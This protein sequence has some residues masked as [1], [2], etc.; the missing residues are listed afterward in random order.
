M[1]GICGIFQLDGTP[2]E[3]SPLAEMNATLAHRGPDDDGFYVASAIGLG[4]RRLSIID[5]G[6]GH[7]PLSNEDQSIWVVFNGEIYNFLDL[8]NELLSQ[9]HSFRT[10]SDT[11]VIAHLY[12]AYGADLLPKLRGMFAFAVW[13]SR[14]RSLLLARDRVGKKPLYYTR[15]GQCLIFASEIKAI[16]KHPAVYA[17]VN[18][19]AIYN[20]LNYQ[21]VP[22]PQTA[23]AGIYKLPPASYLQ[24]DRNSQ[25]IERYWQLNFAPKLNLSE[26]DCCTR[27]RELLEEAV[28]IR[29]MSEVPLGAFLSGGIDSSVIVGLMSKLNSQP[30][31][32]FSIG[33]LEQE[34]NETGYAQ[35]VAKHFHTDHQE[36]TVKPQAL[37]ILPKLIWHYNEPFAD[38][39]ALPTFYVCQMSRRYV[40]VALC[41]DGGDEGFAGYE[42]YLM[43]KWAAI[44][45]KLPD[46]L[47]RSVFAALSRKLAHTFPAQAFFGRLHNFFQR[48]SL[49]AAEL[50]NQ[51]MSVFTP[52]SRQDLYTQDLLAAGCGD[53]LPDLFAQ[54]GDWDNLDRVLWVD[55]HSYLPD[56]L[57]VKAD[58]A[59]MANSL[60]VRSPFLDHKVLEF[61]AGLPSHYK[62]KGLT[63]LKYILRRAFADFL[64]PPILG[65]KKMGFSVPLASWF[66]GELKG[67]VYEVLFSAQSRCRGYFQPHALEKLLVE[68]TSGKFDHSFKLWNLLMLELW[69]RTFIDR[70]G[71]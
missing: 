7:Q 27:L 32:T 33:F 54:T 56:D 10:H 51:L 41:G 15:Q 30:V 28:K 17:H 11:E 43:H 57:L 70:R 71:G 22:S 58:V 21:Y 14:R 62:I 64:P 68:H 67:Y 2:V 12:E 25:R 5:L 60:E 35:I 18:L 13:D 31:K 49:P 61:A 65:R 38:P 69:Q 47:R 9:G 52:A 29:L 42:R 44:Y 45:Q 55:I 6:G 24:I 66:R 34:Y 3:K 16:L 59:S 40:T 48:L 23:F 4:H 1:C 37:E 8:R 20:Y 36:L 50:H 26:A 53:Y 46:R 39:S 19:P 63:Q